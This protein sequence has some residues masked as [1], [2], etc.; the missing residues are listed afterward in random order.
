MSLHT[1]T[2]PV[3]G[4]SKLTR[5]DLMGIRYF[6]P[7]VD[8][9]AGSGG[10]GEFEVID[11]QDKLDKVIGPRLAREREKFKDY[12]E[13][14][15]KASKWTAHEQ[16]NAGNNGDGKGV[17][18]SDTP[19][20]VTPDDVQSR[21]DAALAERDRQHAIDLSGIALGKALETRTYDPTKLLNLDRSQ[22]VKDGK[23]DQAAV[24]AWVQANSQERGA[25]PRTRRT[26]PGQGNRD[27]TAAGGTTQSGR[28]RY[29]NERSKNKP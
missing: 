24:D 6:F 27:A 2:K 14:K 8:D 29:S 28:D 13:L 15:E 16:A 5:H 17:G 10:G 22:F 25:E 12:D 20:N 19:N 3:H 7:P 9:G 21:I 11:S 18:K 1:F 23:F 26:D 4:P